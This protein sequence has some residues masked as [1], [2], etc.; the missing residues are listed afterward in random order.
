MR[1]DVFLSFRGEKIR[2]TFL[3]HLVHSLDRKGIRSVTSTASNPSENQAVRESLVAVSIISNTFTS[4]DLWAEELARIIACK[5]KAV[6]VFLGVDPIDILRV[7]TLAEDSAGVNE[8]WRNT[9]ETVKDWLDGHVTSNSGFNSNDWE[10]DSQLVDQITR[11]ISDTVTQDSV[12]HRWFPGID[13]LTSP[14]RDPRRNPSTA[15]QKLIKF[16][17]DGSSSIG[18][19][20][21]TNPSDEALINLSPDDSP[22]L[23][24]LRRNPR[25]TTIKYSPS[26]VSPP[27]SPDFHRSSSNETMID[28]SSNESPPTSSMLHRSDPSETIIEHSDPRDMKHRIE[29]MLSMLQ[30]GD[31][32]TEVRTIGIYGTEGV[33]K[34]TLAKHVY[35]E[36]SSQFQHHFFITNLSD[37]GSS[38]LEI[39]ASETLD[40]T[41]SFNGSSDVIEEIVGRKV[42][43]IADSVD[44]ITQLKSFAKQASLFGPGSRVMFITQDRSLLFQCGVKHIYQVGCPGYDEA[45]QLFSQFAFRQTKPVSGYESLSGRTV[46]VAGRI[47]L[48]LKVLGSYLYGKDEDEWESTLRTLEESHNNYTREEVLKYIGADDFAPRTPTILELGENEKNP[49]PLYSFTLQ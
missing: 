16:S 27:R 9:L 4:L 49:F 41:T 25:Q 11:F 19:L 32:A 47:P 39:L 18:P 26:Y 38:L 20:L 42:L 48:A 24:R 34:T 29:E 17:S 14:W 6:P 44:D 13:F 31:S 28:F 33:G 45:V 30:L 21:P 46:E 35:E 10:D 8:P 3:S 2:R 37:Q 22:T 43:L 7:L 23:P 1:Y 5:K 36:I 12:S 15:K 40:T